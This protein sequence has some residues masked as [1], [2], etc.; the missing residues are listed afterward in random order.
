MTARDQ[1][2]GLLASQ[3]GAR[4]R[5]L[6]L[7]AELSQGELAARAETHR[8]IIS[9]LER[10]VHVPDLDVLARMA[11]ALD[12]DVVTVLTPLDWAEI[13]RAAQM[14]LAEDRS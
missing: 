6:R 10:G 1:L 7:D 12:V 14:T 3:V 13:D 8:P 9:R 5:A 2:S 4:L 11:R